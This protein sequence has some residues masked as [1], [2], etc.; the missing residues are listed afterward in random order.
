MVGGPVGVNYGTAGTYR[1]WDQIFDR[2]SSVPEEE[3]RYPYHRWRY[4]EAMLTSDLTAVISL[5]PFP[6]LGLSILNVFKYGGSTSEEGDP[7]S[8]RDRNIV[9]IANHETQAFT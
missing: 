8:T 6:Q 4:A 2:L 5:P 9:T 3:C 1:L 7:V